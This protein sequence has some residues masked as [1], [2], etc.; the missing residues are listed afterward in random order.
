MAH[1]R[2]LFYFAIPLLLYF[3][4]RHRARRRR[5]RRLPPNQERVLILGATSGIGRAIARL[6][7]ARGA[8]ICII[9]RRQDRLESARAECEAARPLGGG[10]IILAVP[11]DFTNPSSLVSL[12][13][14]LQKGIGAFPS[15]P[16]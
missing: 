5:R 16:A 1:P 7:A 15:L 9:G 4:A 11:A 13:E 8:R 2:L 14:T 12:R 6:Y 10:H 3:L